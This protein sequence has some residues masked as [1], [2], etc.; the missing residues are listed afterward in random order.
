MEKKPLYFQAITLVL[1]NAFV[2]AWN[3]YLIGGLLLTPLFGLIFVPLYIGLFIILVAGFKQVF[4]GKRRA[5]GYVLMFLPLIVWL[6][7]GLS[8][9]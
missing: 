6:A 1:I 7:I 9:G 2:L 5:I 3:L 8:Y 4:N